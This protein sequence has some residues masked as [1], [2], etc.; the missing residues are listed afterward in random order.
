VALT[1]GEEHEHGKR[2][3]Q[4]RDHD[5]LAVSLPAIRRTEPGH[6][7]RNPRGSVEA[8]DASG[9]EVDQRGLQVPAGLEFEGEDHNQGRYRQRQCDPAG[10]ALADA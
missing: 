3:E 6:G 10:Q 9:V 1:K 2:D 4:R 8:F 5:V 7:V